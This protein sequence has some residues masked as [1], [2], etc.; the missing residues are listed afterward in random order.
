MESLARARNLR[1]APTRIQLVIDQIR[2]KDVQ[3]ALN[4]LE[5]SRKRIAKAVKEA[6]KSAIANAENNH[7]LDVDSLYVSR[8]HVDQGPMLKRFL[9]RARGRASR[10]LKRTSHLTVAVSER[11]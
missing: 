10:I 2:G 9:P 5:F 11:E 8:I 4:V 7:G 3:S 6:L 1:V